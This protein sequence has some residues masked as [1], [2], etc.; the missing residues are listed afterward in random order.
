[1]ELT[2]AGVIIVWGHHENGARRVIEILTFWGIHCEF[3]AP[4]E[5]A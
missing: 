4:F 3:W 5:L 2:S 1:V